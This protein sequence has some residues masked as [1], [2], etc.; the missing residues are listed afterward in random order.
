M[1]LIR[2]ITITNSNDETYYQRS[3]RDK[4]MLAAGSILLSGYTLGWL[5][6]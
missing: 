1:S 5:V 6:L 2:P 4:S 3:Y